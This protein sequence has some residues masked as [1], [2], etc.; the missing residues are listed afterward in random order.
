MRSFPKV[1]QYLAVV[2]IQDSLVLAE[3]FPS[4]PVHARLLSSPVFRRVSL[5]PGSLAQLTC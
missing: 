3:K 1:L 5:R 4:N 2:L